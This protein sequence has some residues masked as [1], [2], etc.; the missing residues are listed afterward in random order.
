MVQALKFAQV[1]NPVIMIDEVDK[2]GVSYQGD[3]ASAL[4]EVLD[5]EQNKDF[6]DHY[7]DVRC[8]LSK[9]LFIVTANI[10]DTIPEPL[11]DRMDILRLSGYILQEK[12]EIAR[13]YLIPRNR[14]TMGLKTSDVAF[15]KTALSQIINGYAR[16]AG[17]RSLENYIKKILRKVAMKLVKTQRKKRKKKNEKA[18][19]TSRIL[20]KFI[21][22]PIFTT[23]RYYEKTPVGVCMG[24][25][26]TAMGG[27]TL[28][29]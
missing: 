15:D 25:A 14:K 29:M 3:P 11:K 21:G 26:W 24:L 12:I 1:M 10:L 22:K 4:L 16:E 2:M 9:V 20:D 28:Y 27:A 19:I 6:L 18:T 7:L 8:D 13:R 5:P 23:D 17:V